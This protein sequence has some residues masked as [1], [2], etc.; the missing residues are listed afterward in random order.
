M[1]SFQ[2]LLNVLGMTVYTMPKKI[3]NWPMATY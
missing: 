1:R 2:P 3:A